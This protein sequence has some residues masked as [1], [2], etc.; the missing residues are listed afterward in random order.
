MGSSCSKDGDPLWYGYMPDGKG[1]TVRPK[2]VY[3]TSPDYNSELRRQMKQQRKAQNAVAYQ[4]PNA[5]NP[6]MNQQPNAYNHQ[7]SQQPNGYN[8]RMAP[9]PS[10]YNPSIGQQPPYNLQI[11]QQPSAYDPNDSAPPPYHQA[12]SDA[13]KWGYL[14]DAKGWTPT[15]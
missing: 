10:A 7:M 5:Y 1:W 13:S 9:Q 3:M 6:Q 14:N 15:K 11:N 8:A 4:Q 2:S 12:N